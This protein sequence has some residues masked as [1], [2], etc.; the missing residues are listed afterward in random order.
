MSVKF[1][2]STN[3][4]K[5]VLT[6]PSPIII[7][8]TLQ[9]DD[10]FVQ[11]ND[12]KVLFKQDDPSHGYVDSQF[13]PKGKVTGSLI[14]DKKVYDIAGWGLFVKATQLRPQNPAQW[15][16]MTFQNETDAL[17]LYQVPPTNYAHSFTTIIT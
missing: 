3:T 15:N 17:H 9:A 6:A 4:Y 1:D 13:I 12:G 8:L 14:V 7:D 10:G 5:A 16:F 11:V 2:P